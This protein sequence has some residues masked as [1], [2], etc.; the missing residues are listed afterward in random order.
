MLWLTDMLDLPSPYLNCTVAD[1]DWYFRTGSGIF[2]PGA[3]RNLFV[4]VRSNLVC[5]IPSLKPA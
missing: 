2:L 3:T 1:R 4:G 5:P